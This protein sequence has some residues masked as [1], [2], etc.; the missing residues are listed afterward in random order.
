MGCGVNEETNQVEL[1]IPEATDAALRLLAELDPT[2][3]AILVW[4]GPAASTGQLQEP[5]ATIQPG[6]GE[7]P[8][9][10][11]VASAR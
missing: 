1:D 3:D 10:E 9:R 7:L 4:V 5:G 8:N 6:D 2:D 11:K